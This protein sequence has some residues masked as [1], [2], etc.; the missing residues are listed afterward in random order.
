MIIPKTQ[1]FESSNDCFV[2]INLF[3]G[4]IPWS[5]PASPVW[6]MMIFTLHSFSLHFLSL[7][8]LI[9]HSAADTNLRFSINGFLVNARP[10][11]SKEEREPFC[12]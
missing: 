4:I 3:L 8:Q 9:V 1:K 11:V 6:L 10:S 7:L 12:A 5:Y 2:T